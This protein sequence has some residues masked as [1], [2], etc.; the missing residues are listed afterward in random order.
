M[1]IDSGVNFFDVAPYYGLKLAES[2]LG[3]ALADRRNEVILATKC[4]RYGADEFDFSSQ[5]TILEVDESL[6]RL[7]TDYVDLL[8]VHDV[9]FGDVEQIV[10]ETLP[11]LRGLQKAGKARYIGITGYSLETLCKIAESA[12]VD[13][14]LSY[15][16]YN[17]M[18]RDMDY[19]LTP[20]AKARSIGL[21]NASPLHMGI[22]SGNDV[23]EWHPAP[24]AIRAV[25]HF[26]DEVCSAQG[27]RVAEV[28]LRFCLGHP[29]VATTLIGMANVE[30]VEQNLKALEVADDTSAIREIVVALGPNFNYV[31]PSGK[32]I[33]EEE[34]LVESVCR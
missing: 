23:P 22:L 32:K 15:C 30:Q 31:W 28:A 10:N 11:T 5:R 13:S 21:I 24:Q 9:E 2:R 34:N 27:L 18:V 16:R 29:Y 8:Q 19:V 1:A 33:Q 26:A 17:L 7:Q 25:G 6:E 12:P 4:G 14:I 3:V 20:L